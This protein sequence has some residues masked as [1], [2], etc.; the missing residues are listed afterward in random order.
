MKIYVTALYEEWKANMEVR[1]K[2]LGY[3]ITDEEGG[4]AV[5]VHIYCGCR[6]CGQYGKAFGNYRV[7]G[8]VPILLVRG[9][10]ELT[11]HGRIRG[12]VEVNCANQELVHALW[13]TAK[14]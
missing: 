14:L 2:A 11:P 13:E 4:V 12:S 9:D 8:T 3:E 10:G 1:L 7:D 5:H 6:G